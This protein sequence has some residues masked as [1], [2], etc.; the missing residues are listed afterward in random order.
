MAR[1]GSFRFLSPT[2]ALGA[3]LY[4]AG[5]AA[6]VWAQ[7]ETRATRTLPGE[8]FGVVTGDFNGDGKLDLAVVDGQL[9]I[10][11]GN[12]DGTFHAPINYPGVRGLWIAAADFN[13]DGK[14][15]LI[16]S[17]AS[18]TVSVLL[19]N[20]DGTF[21][22]PITSNTTSDPSFV[23]V[24]YFNNDKIPDIAIV[25]PPYI[26]V[27]LGNGDGTFQS[28]S[29]NESFVGPQQLA[30]GDFNNDHQLDV[31]VVGFFGGSQDVGV[32][33]GNGDG[34]L[35]SS[36]TYPLTYTPNSV[37]AADFNRDG[38]LD[39]AIGGAG[40]G[41]T[42]LLGNGDGSFQ[43]EVDYA[44]T[45]GGGEVSVADFDGDGNLDLAFSAAI[46]P[47]LNEL[48]GDGNGTFQPAAFYPAGRF[49][50]ALA[51]GDFNSDHKLD[52]EY[53]DRDLG[54]ITLLN[55]G[56]LSFSPSTP[57]GFPSAQL[58]GTASAP[59]MVTLANTGAAAVSVQSIT[60]SGQFQT[61]NNC[62]SQLAAGAH[63]TV[64]AVFEPKTAGPRRGLMTLNDSASSKP[65]IVEL[66]GRGTFVALSPK[67]LSFAPRKVG[68][69]SP[70][71]RLS[72]TNDGST[73]LIVSSIG[74]GGS[75]AKDF[76]VSGTGN[77]TKQ[78]L[79]PGAT[80]NVTVTFAPKK[81]GVRSAQLFVTDSGAGSPEV[82]AL[83]GTGT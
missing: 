54:T 6:P 12:G 45:G 58:V 51:I 31:V 47:G 5:V 38:N 74:V 80:C 8:A 37:A 35:Q 15:D 26:S 28:P 70:P 83:A 3:L 48:L 16:L 59:V 60:A 4:F 25:D 81:T 17:T 71:Q 7:F 21:Q 24:G 20:G 1:L 77:C 75:G 52:V 11:L 34:T 29:D 23:A 55:T 41:V 2:F 18:N 49:S 53:V 69:T 33:L 63:C 10:L 82:A 9:S 22:A 72:I 57:L 68:T 42:I 36:L 14:L 61:S 66:S 56:A 43:P 76:A 50:G 32:L 19:G 27:L 44:T 39:A 78:E 13:R 79:A 73:S 40:T 62:G 65:Q 67:A 30:V 64:S 46:P